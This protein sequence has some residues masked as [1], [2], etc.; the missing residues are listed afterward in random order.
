MV[1]LNDMQVSMDN[2]DKSK[3]LDHVIEFMHIAPDGTRQ[4][5]R[6]F[7]QLA[8]WV[9][10]ALNVFPLLKLGLCNVYDKMSSKT[11]AHTKIFVSQ[12]VV[13]DL[14]WLTQ[15]VVGSSGIHIFETMD[16]AVD[17]A[18]LVAYGDASGIRMGFYFVDL[19]TDYQL[20]LP[21]SPPKDMIFYFEA[22]TVLA[23]IKK[24]CILSPLPKCLVVFS[25]NSNTV[26]IFSSLCAKSDYNGILNATVTLLLDCKVG[27]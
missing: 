11:E 9:N 25:D 3:L 15:I 23:I 17:D 27:L 26:D 20:D 21:H 7:Q 8:G 18:N 22:L 2:I 16:W 4:I 5:L 19:K 14:C 24:A 1:D 13:D 6:E 10:W 12:A